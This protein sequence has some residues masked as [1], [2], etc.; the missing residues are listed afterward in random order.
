MITH[1]HAHTDNNKKV[2]DERRTWTNVVKGQAKL[3]KGK[4]NGGHHGGTAVLDF[5]G[6]DKGSSVLGSVFGS[7]LV[8]I[9]LSEKDWKFSSHWS[10]WE[11][12][13]GFLDFQQR[14]LVAHAEGRRGRSRL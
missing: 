11:A 10:G 4:A 14:R 3:V 5:R 12:R 2:N 1:T 6:L 7:E 8:P 9:I 13:N